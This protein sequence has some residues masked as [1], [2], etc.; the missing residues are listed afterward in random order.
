MQ[1]SARCRPLD[2]SVVHILPVRRTR[3]CILCIGPSAVEALVSTD[4][5]LASSDSLLYLF[6]P[7]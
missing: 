7:G 5:S 3:L 6:R 4:L 1:L 2:V